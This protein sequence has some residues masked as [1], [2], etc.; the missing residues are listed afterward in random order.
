MTKGEIEIES[1]K[2]AE[3]IVKLEQFYVPGRDR[4]IELATMPD[5]T[6]AL[7]RLIRRTY[8]Y[9]CAKGLIITRSVEFP[10]A[11]PAQ[12]RILARCKDFYGIDLEQREFGICHPETT[13]QTEREI[14]K[15]MP[16]HVSDCYPTAFKEWQEHLGLLIPRSDPSLN[17]IRPKELRI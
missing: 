2:L 12:C 15:S 10:A 4:K 9:P 13:L 5:Y 8:V 16:T 14:C 3:E 6:S 1:A 7:A 11:T 17:L